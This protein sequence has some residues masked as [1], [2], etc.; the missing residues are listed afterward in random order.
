MSLAIET[1]QVLQESR[2][3]YVRVSSFCFA[4]RWVSLHRHHKYSTVEDATRNMEQSIEIQQHARLQLGLER[5]L[6][7]SLTTV[8][9]VYVGYT[10]ED[11]KSGVSTREKSRR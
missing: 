8:S 7:L 3:G 5:R 4:V 9:R 6:A 10:Q 2:L 11:T 1:R